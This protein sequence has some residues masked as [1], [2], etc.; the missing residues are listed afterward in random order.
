AGAVYKDTVLPD[1]NAGEALAELD[2]HVLKVRALGQLGPG[3]NVS[4]VMGNQRACLYRVGMGHTA[5]YGR[6]AA[7]FRISHKFPAFLILDYLIYLPISRLSFSFC[8]SDTSS[9]GV[10]MAAFSAVAQ[11]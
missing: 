1:H 2:I 8:S 4:E 3:G 10:M 11:P 9:R 5:D 6:G 7:K